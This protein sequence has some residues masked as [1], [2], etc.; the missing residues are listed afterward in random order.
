ML[1][2]DRTGPLGEIGESSVGKAWR[3]RWKADSSKV[4]APVCVG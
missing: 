3:V 1:I 4:V 2:L